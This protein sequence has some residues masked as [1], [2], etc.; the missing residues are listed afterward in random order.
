VDLDRCA[1][2]TCR[3]ELH[4][5]LGESMQHHRTTLGTRTRTEDNHLKLHHAR[6]C[7][8]R[9]ATHPPRQTA[10]SDINANKA[11]DGRAPMAWELIVMCHPP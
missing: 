4:G 10:G 6:R 3:A 2:S 9:E 7:A 1:A 5:G 11:W 8:C